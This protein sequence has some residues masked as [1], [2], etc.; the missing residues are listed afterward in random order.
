M[1][2]DACHD[3]RYKSLVAFICQIPYNVLACLF[4][5][6]VWFL[7]TFVFMWTVSI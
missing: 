6:K 3:L 5:H 4:L 2:V 1:V 7:N